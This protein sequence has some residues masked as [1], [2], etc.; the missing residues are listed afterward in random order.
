MKAI[1]LDRDGV[2][3]KDKGYLFKI[4]DF[5]FIE[6]VF[7]VLKFFQEKKYLIFIITNQSG[8]NRGIY[9]LK[10]FNK[11]THWMIKEFNIRQINITNVYFC[12]HKP[13]EECECRKPKPKM[14]FDAGKRYNL[15]LSN[16][17][18]IGD[19]ISDIEAGIKAGI[20]NLFLFSQRPR[21]IDKNEFN[22]V[23][24]KKI[25]ELKNLF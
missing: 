25:K 1:F 2:I 18:L 9:N 7:D 23:K 24:I 15:D 19:K 17:I 16:S 13:E 11:L 5:E 4:D 14:I 10:D 3:N 22:I 8:I 21:N 6:G 20:K 12:P